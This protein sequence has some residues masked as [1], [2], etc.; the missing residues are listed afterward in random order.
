MAFVIKT[1]SDPRR[2][3]VA[4]LRLLPMPVAVLAAAAMLAWSQPSAAQV[5][6]QRHLF[7]LNAYG[8]AARPLD[9]LP[10]TRM[11]PLQ[12]AMTQAYPVI[13]VN[14]DGSD[15]WPCYGRNA[16]NGDCFAAGNPPIQ[17][18]EGSFVTGVPAYSWALKNNDIFGF[19]LG[20]GT[21]CD[22]FI[23]GTAGITAAEYKPCGQLTTFFEDDT[24][25][26]NDDLLQ[27]IVVT[28]GLNVVYD[29]G[30]VDF[31]PAGPTVKY[32]VDVELAYDANFGFWPGAK[33]GPNNGNCSADFGYPLAAAAFP[34]LPYQV[35]AGSTCRR[36]QAGKAHVHT[37][38][39]LAT[40]GY[41]E[42][43]GA[44]CTAHNVAS[45][46]FTVSWEQK[47]QIVQDWDIF[48][49]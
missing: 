8:A 14:A 6:A 20:N 44:K 38:T 42:V 25:D 19:G 29:S 12:A 41:T 31:G 48:F 34:G 37:E 43:T 5:H 15:L 4:R 3:R 9:A 35:A 2:A 30:I 17:L 1:P 22:A 26:A 49:R 13:G 47:Y 27:R 39:V 33:N 21:G 16:G 10:P 28:Q 24:N 36:P 46:C 7:S 32:P 18:P 45:P 40:P 23:N 11:I